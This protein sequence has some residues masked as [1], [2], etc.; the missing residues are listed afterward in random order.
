MIRSSLA[1]NASFADVVVTYS[2]GVLM[3]ARTITGGTVTST[4]GSS[5]ATATYWVKLVRT[6]NTFT[7]YCSPDGSTWTLIGTY[8]VAMTDPVYVGIPVSSSNDG[9]LATATVDNVTLSSLP[10]V[11]TGLTAVAAA[12]TQVG[13]SW[14]RGS[15]NDN[16]FLV[17]RSADGATNWTQIGTTA[18]G[19]TT[20]NDT[21]LTPGSTWYYRV[22]ATNATGNSGYSN[23]ASVTLPTL[24]SAPSSLHTTLVSTSEIDIAWTNNATNATSIQVFRQTLPGGTPSLI[25]T[26][27]ATAASYQDN[28]APLPAGTL[29]TYNIQAYN[30][31]GYSGAA[32]VATATLAT[33]PTSVTANSRHRADHRQLARLERRHQL[34]RLPVHHV[35]RRGRR[36]VCDRRDD[37]EFQ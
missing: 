21:A 29:Q 2:N 28:S 27:P 15:T 7:G 32:S 25:A 35:R 37:R 31:A 18:A 8:T 22:R 9:Y 20:Y 24:P 12:G 11:P 30:L 16:G 4:Q 3:Q 10:A 5:T 33:A 14:N 26:L 17:E 23:V 13:L 19:V 6:G 34:Q 1:G 36:A